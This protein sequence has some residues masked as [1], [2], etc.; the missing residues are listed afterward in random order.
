MEDKKSTKEELLR[1]I[2]LVKLET[3]PMNYK[4]SLGNQGIFDKKELI[5]HINKNDNIGKQILDMELR[6]M[7]AISKGEVTR[8]LTSI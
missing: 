6:F 7:K 3:M 2:V 4:L 5:E 1:E 8:T